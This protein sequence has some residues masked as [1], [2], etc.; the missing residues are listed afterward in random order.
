MS[1]TSD[2]RAHLL[3]VSGITDLVGTRIFYDSLQQGCDLPAVVL[4]LTDSRRADVH[5]DAEGAQYRAEMTVYG[6][7]DSRS[8]SDS[9][10]DALDAALSF[11]TGT[12]DSTTINR[13]LVEHWHDIVEEPRDGSGQWRYLRALFTIVW[14][15]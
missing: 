14:H 15:E 12:W 13:S 9:L 8:G 11:K 6:Y 4:E 5:L 7:A 1:V 3:T 10:G 2:M